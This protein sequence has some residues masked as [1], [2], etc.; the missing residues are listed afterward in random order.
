MAGVIV[1]SAFGTGNGYGIGDGK[2]D[3]KQ[4]FVPDME[5]RM[6]TETPKIN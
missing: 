2:F 3:I 6:E 4:T 5:A 1:A